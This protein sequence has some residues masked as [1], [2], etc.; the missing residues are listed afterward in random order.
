MFSSDP[1]FII[2]RSGGVGMCF[3]VFK[4]GLLV[5]VVGGGYGKTT[6]FWGEV[7]KGG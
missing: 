3:L 2:Q 4:V 5:G 1:L 6:A 7:Y